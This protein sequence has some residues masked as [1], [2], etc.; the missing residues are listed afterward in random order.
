[1]WSLKRFVLVYTN[2]YYCFEFCPGNG[3]L[4][5]F[6]I[7]VNNPIIT[8]IACISAAFYWNDSLRRQM[9]L[10]QH[11]RMDWELARRATKRQ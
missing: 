10:D 2:F 5:G 1:V 8:I 3:H 7:A 6:F 11:Q 4:Y 9:W